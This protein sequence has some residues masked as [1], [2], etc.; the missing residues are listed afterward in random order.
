[1]QNVIVVFDIGKTNKKCFLFNE[2]YEI[3]FEKTTNTKE[4]PDDDGFMGDNIEELNNWLSDT[5]SEVNLLNFAI[6]A[7]NFSGYGASFVL[8]N[9]SGVPIAPL[10]NYLKPFNQK[11]LDEFYTKYGGKIEFPKLTASPILGNLNSG[12]QLLSLKNEKPELFK[13]LYYA[14]HLPQYLSSVFTNQFYSE[15]T[16]V[17]CHTNLWDYTN[18]DYHQWV[19]NE[20]I[21]KLL[22][23]ILASDFTI[24]KNNVSIGIGLHDSSSALI[25]Y[26]IT[27]KAP[28]LLISTGTW[29]ISLNPFNNYPLTTEQ[30][31]MD[32]LANLSYQGNP[33]KSARLFAGHFHEIE[34][35]KIAL[36]FG[37]ANDFYKSIVYNPNIKTIILEHVDLFN[38]PFLNI[39]LNQF[40]TAEIAYHQLIY[41]LV[42]QQF[43]STSLV[44]N[45]IVN[46]IFVDGGFS[47][48][49]IYM[50]YLALAFPEKQIYAAEVAQASALG[51]ALV[52]HNEWNS[53]NIPENLISIKKY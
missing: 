7:L 3:V 15:I 1:M 38:S 6:K 21:D 43:V 11:L 28:F 8:I 49:E 29:C 2:A 42:S 10:Y 25:P 20:G 4:I 32:C 52:I 47:K 24:K 17:G 48:N 34:T 5:W 31:Q 39:G 46:Q 45:N 44:L 23:P 33:V 16:S 40:E 50:K 12:M 22:A 18:M 30:L 13:K 35:K 26:L 14:L 27:E 36:Y 53:K 37:L 19:E 9:E 51:A 41:A